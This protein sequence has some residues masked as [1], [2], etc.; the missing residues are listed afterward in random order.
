MGSGVRNI[1]KYNKVYSGADPVFIESDVFKTTI[2]LVSEV[3]DHATVQANEDT[4]RLLVF[5]RTARK[6]LK[7][8]S[9]W[10]I[11]TGIISERMFGIL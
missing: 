6:E 10:N 1:Y 5:C 9:I 4:E 7:S 3:S 2:P 11:K 8:K